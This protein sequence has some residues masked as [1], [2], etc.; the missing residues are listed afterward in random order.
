[1]KANFPVIW[2][3]DNTEFMD[4][5]R[6]R[7]ESFL[8]DRGFGLQLTHY[9]SK[10]DQLFDQLASRDVELIMVD[11]SLGD[12]K[13][14]SLIREIRKRGNYQEVI[15]YTHGG[16]SKEVRNSGLEGVFFTGRAD[17]WDRL[18]NVIEWK[19]RRYSD[20]TIVRGWIVAD[21]IELELMVN[22]LLI[23]CLEKQGTFFDK[24]FLS[25]MDRD[26]SL[27]FK[28]K[29]DILISIVK[30]LVAF[31]NDQN[32]NSPR[33][34][35]LRSC[36]EILN[37]FDEEVICIRN[38]IA[39]QNAETTDDGQIKVKTKTGK[40]KDIFINEETC[41]AI[42]KDMRKHQVNLVK[43]KELLSKSDG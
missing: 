11:Y 20:L 32:Q 38:A 41:A 16:I 26:G 27:G 21:A 2:I 40:P 12:E 9:E 18:K 17:T 4:S 6:D 23:L 13:G 42:R 10:V 22:G 15:F 19:A 25:I 43:L 37:K 36:K 34:I 31:L 7:L 33:A 39:H 8:E 14:D 30:E 35:G 5:L 24:H 29:V 3:D 28:K 1:M